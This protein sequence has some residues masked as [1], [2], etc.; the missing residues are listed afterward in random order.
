[1][2]YY[3]DKSVKKSEEIHEVI[4]LI[5]YDG[6]QVEEHPLENIVKLKKSGSEVELTLSRILIRNDRYTDKLIINSEG[7]ALIHKLSKLLMEK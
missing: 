7:L 6:W 3:K 2:N 1:M 4:E 5:K